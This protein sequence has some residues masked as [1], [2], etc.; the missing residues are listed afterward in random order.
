MTPRDLEKAFHDKRRA[1]G[2]APAAIFA[3][4]EV[5]SEV[6]RATSPEFYSYFSNPIADPI[7]FMGRPIIED[8]DFDGAHW[9][10]EAELEAY[11]AKQAA[12]KARMVSEVADYRRHWE[13]I[14]LAN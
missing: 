11:Q 10:G 4:P 9:A 2:N 1:T 12:H 5:F 8:V 7:T 14:V 6:I 13:R 3:H